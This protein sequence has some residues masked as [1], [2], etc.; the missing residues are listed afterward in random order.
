MLV[1]RYNSDLYRD[2]HQLIVI[3][4]TGQSCR[5]DGQFPPFGSAP[6]WN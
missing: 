3:T 4:N 5:G 1:L 6:A 2:W